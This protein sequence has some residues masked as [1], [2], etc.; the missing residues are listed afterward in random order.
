MYQAITL[1]SVDYAYQCK[2]HKLWYYI[3]LDTHVNPQLDLQNDFVIIYFFISPV[4][5]ELANYVLYNS[6]HQEVHQSIIFVKY[7]KT[8]GQAN[9]KENKYDNNIIQM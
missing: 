9:Q 5:L 3:T 7:L 4:V 6:L 8:S 1:C 2:A